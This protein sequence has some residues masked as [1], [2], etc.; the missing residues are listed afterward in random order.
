MEYC[1]IGSR[2]TMLWV[3][4]CFVVA[5]VLLVLLI[6]LEKPIESTMGSE[7]RIRN[8]AGVIMPYNKR[9]AG[10]KATK[11]KIAS[12]KPR[13]IVI[14]LTHMSSGSTF[15]G[16][17]FNLYPD[18]FYVY[19]PLHTLRR[20]V[21]GD[22]N[23]LDEWNVL[24]KKAEDA[25]RTD[26]SNLL[27]KFFT[28]N[29]KGNKTIQNLFPGWLRR[30]K[31][32]LA[33]RRAGTNFTK[34]SVSEVCKS[35]RITVTKI[36]QTRLPGKFGIRDL[37]RVCSSEPG[38]FDCLIIHLVRDPRAVISSLISH[39]F[40]F[41]TKKELIA[42]QHATPEGKE[43]IRHNSF[44]VCSLIQANLNYVNEHWSSWFRGRYTLLRYEDIIGNL[45]SVAF[46]L[47]NFTGLPMV[48]SVR[49]WILEGIWPL[50]VNAT[51]PAFV[52]SENDTARIEHWR[53]RLDTS[54]VTEFEEL[55]SPVMNMMGYKSINGSE[56]LLHNTTQKLWTEKMPLKFPY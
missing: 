24:D 46:Q 17:L 10:S 30:R 44:I 5:E 16:N 23:G 29:F 52:T 50:D 53:S 45:F 26:F 15:L 33:W 25:Y 21:H 14:I 11:A 9:E 55:C 4:L 20:E 42:T 7:V 56:H 47:Y 48:D 31:N 12:N 43:I 8:T 2:S 18:V 28:C 13:L 37:Q 27:H 1:R 35:K 49:N 19:E 36:M 39:Q 6:N 38:K 34:E 40:Y 22:G 3:F 32:Y 41:E 51:N 54:Q